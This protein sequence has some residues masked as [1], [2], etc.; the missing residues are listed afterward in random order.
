MSIREGFKKK[1][2]QALRILLTPPES[3]YGMILDC[4]LLSNVLYIRHWFFYNQR[5]ISEGVRLMHSSY[6]FFTLMG[7]ANRFTTNLQRYQY[8]NR[9]EYLCNNIHHCDHLWDNFTCHLGFCENVV[10]KW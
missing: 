7:M 3:Y 1:F 2:L 6:H 9:G 4:D 8:P 10:F 5:M